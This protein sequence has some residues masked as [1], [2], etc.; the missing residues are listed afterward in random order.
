MAHDWPFWARP[1][2]L[3]PEGDWHCWLFMGGRGAGKTRAGAEWVRAN[4]FG[5]LPYSPPQGPVALIG[6]DLADAREVIIEGPSGLKAVCAPSERPVWVAS[7]RR[8]EWPNGLYAQLFSAQDPDSLRGPQFAL[9]WADEIAK[10]AY[11]EHTW[12]ML[13]F[14]LRLGDKPRV[15]AT[16][17]PRPVPLLKR[18]LADPGTVVTRAGTSDN[19]AFLAPGFVEA[20][21]ARYGSSAL[22]RQELFGELVEDR[23]GAFWTRAGLEAAR[24]APPACSRIVVAVDPPASH[25]RKA[26]ACGIV[27][28]GA[29]EG[30][31]AVLADA[32]VQGESP[33]G[34]A[35]RALALYETLRADA[36]IAEVNQ[37][38][39]MVQ[40]LFAS[41]A[42]HVAV[43]GVY[44]TRGKQ[45]RAEPIAALYAAGRV[46][47]AGNFPALEDEMCDFSATGLSNGRSPDRLDALVWAVTALM[48]GEGAPRVRGV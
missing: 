31:F 41:L 43:K 44:A 2:Q 28:A 5:R 40:S 38:G 8:L 15:M 37:G 42:P 6:D 33:E 25:S 26:D 3:P 14:G 29:F 39:A 10:W 18:L 9:C 48:E 23:P 46:K 47:H 19:A 13:S 22:G 34:W 16:T 36:L 1:A 4:V 7:R 32:S 30:G 35:A 24:I 11:G 45:A 27:A 17:T 20:L 12:D 21:D